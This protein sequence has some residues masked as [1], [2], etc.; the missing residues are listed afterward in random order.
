M[1][2]RER[3]DAAV[4]ALAQGR[5]VLVVDDV[6][7]E[8]E[9]DVIFAAQHV[10]DEQIAF[11]MREC[12]GLICVPM[13]PQDVDRLDLPLMVADNADPFRTAFTVSVDASENVTTGISAAERALTARML[14][15]GSSVRAD[16]TAPGH[17]FPLRAKAGG[18]HARRGHTEAAVDLTRAAGL[19]PAGVICEVADDQGRMMSGSDL[20]A[21][22]QRH[23]LPMVSIEDLVQVL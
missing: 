11:L 1:T 12:R 17:I 7:R 5:G 22:A 2:P 19:A 18:V 13:A 9:G 21:F 4:A 16:F 23:Q 3:V 14:A 8:N 15:D 6:D 20:E 10:T